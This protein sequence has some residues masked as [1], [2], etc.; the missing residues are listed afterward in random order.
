MD[1]ASSCWILTKHNDPENSKHCQ[2]VTF[3]LGMQTMQE[4]RCFQLV[5]ILFKLLWYGSPKIV[6]TQMSFPEIT[7]HFVCEKSQNLWFWEPT[8]VLAPQEGLDRWRRPTWR[9]WSREV[10]HG[11]QLN[12]LLEVV[13]NCLKTCWSL[14]CGSE[15]LRWT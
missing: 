12:G 6:K 7:S 4:L 2:W 5:G 13:I 3:L 10:T 8:L 15:M 9:S 14:V 11:L 1:S